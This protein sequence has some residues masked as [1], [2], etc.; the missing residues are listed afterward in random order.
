MAG[1]DRKTV[2]AGSGRWLPWL[3]VALIIV[4][5]DQLTKL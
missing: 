4:A 1:V 5:L 3:V 2:R